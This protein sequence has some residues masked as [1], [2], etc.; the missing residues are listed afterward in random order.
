[1]TSIFDAYDLRGVIL[2][3]WI[4]VLPACEYSC[5]GAGVGAVRAGVLGAGYQDSRPPAHVL[6][7]PNDD[8]GDIGL[9]Q[10]HE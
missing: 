3:D 10:T 2:K 7:G 5:E 8:V 4:G 9:A 6:P 1:M